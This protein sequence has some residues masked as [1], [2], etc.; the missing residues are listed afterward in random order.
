MSGYNK[1]TVVAVTGVLSGSYSPSMFPEPCRFCG[2]VSKDGK[3][4]WLNY[5]ICKTC[6]DSYNNFLVEKLN[7]KDFDEKNTQQIVKIYNKNKKLIP[8]HLMFCESM[9]KLIL[10]HIDD[11]TF[12]LNQLS[13]IVEKG[14]KVDLKIIRK[15]VKEIQKLRLLTKEIPVFNKEWRNKK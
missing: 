12:T 5:Q 6:G 9:N 3:L 7:A 4:G 2:A 11:E 13:K 10:Y 15:N 8:K 1:E 14:R